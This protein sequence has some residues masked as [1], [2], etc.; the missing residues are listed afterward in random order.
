MYT[1]NKKGF[2]WG[3]GSYLINKKGSKKLMSIYYDNKYHLNEKYKHIGYSYPGVP[4]G[5]KPVVEKAM[6]DIEKA[7][8]PSWIP[9]FI[10]RK[11]MALAKSEKYCPIMTSNH[12]SF[13]I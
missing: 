9:M 12:F 13:F 1:L 3:A 11:T 6:K 5:W 8:W 4:K 10:K 2:I 7:M